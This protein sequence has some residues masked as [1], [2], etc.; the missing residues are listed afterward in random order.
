MDKIFTT[1]VIMGAIQS[2]PLYW[3]GRRRASWA[4]Q[5]KIAPQSPGGLARNFIIK[6]HGDF[7]YM[8]DKLS[9]GDALEFG[10]KETN[11]AGKITERAQVYGV[12]RENGERFVVEMFDNSLD[13][14]KVSEAVRAG[15][16]QFA[17]SL[18]LEQQLIEIDKQLAELQAQRTQLLA[19]SGQV[20][21]RV[22]Q[23]KADHG[24][25]GLISIVHHVPPVVHPV[26]READESLTR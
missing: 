9:V 3:S 12:V 14:I 7:L 20:T 23:H 21:P 26:E 10:A 4:A 6:A 1:P 5:I 22:T 19:T 11:Y 13:A 16:A 24:Q 17:V 8:V 18:T 15:D 2:A 25:D